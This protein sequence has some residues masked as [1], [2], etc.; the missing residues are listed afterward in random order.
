MIGPL[1]KRSAMMGRYRPFHLARI[2]PWTR[3]HSLHAVATPPARRRMIVLDTDVLSE[4]LR[5]RPDSDVLAWLTTI[6]EETGVTPVSIGELLTG[7]RA[8]PE[9]RR[10]AGLLDAI[11]TTLQR[12]AGSVLAYDDVAGRAPVARST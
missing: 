2:D 11:E 9:G 12:F 1:V 4:P 3:E 5:R 7:A 10:R 6:D 8:L